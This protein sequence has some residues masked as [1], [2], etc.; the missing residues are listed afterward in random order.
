MRRWATHTYDSSVRGRTMI[1][2]LR[3]N[4]TVSLGMTNNKRAAAQLT[5]EWQA[6]YLPAVLAK[7]SRCLHAAAWSSSTTR[8]GSVPS[9][10]VS[11]RDNTRAAAQL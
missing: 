1:V 10:S 4:K 2:M 8:L 7:A 6:E 5:A 9:K 11:R 3:L